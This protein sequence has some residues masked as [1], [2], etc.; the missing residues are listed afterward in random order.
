MRTTTLYAACFLLLA[1]VS[2]NSAAEKP[3]AAQ[4]EHAA[5]AAQ[6][7]PANTDPVCGMANDGTW[8]EFTVYNNDTVRFCSTT[9]KDAFLANPAKYQR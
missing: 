9:C 6:A 8:T 7:D 5:P 4:E 3:G 1:A 2:C